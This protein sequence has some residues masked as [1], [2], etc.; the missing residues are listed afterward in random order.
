MGVFFFSLARFPPPKFA[1]VDTLIRL[2]HPTVSGQ[3]LRKNGVNQGLPGNRLSDYRINSQ[4][5]LKVEVIVKC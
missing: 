2:S 1:S 3:I 4:G 5:G